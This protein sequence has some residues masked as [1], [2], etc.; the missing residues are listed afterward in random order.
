MWTDFFV[1][2]WINLFGT[3]DGPLGLDWGFWASMAVVCLFV[4][5]QNLFF[6]SRKPLTDEE[7]EERRRSLE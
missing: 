1:S 6:W 7:V 4:V 2:L 5:I 3:V